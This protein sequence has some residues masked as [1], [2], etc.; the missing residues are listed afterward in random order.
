ML[1]ILA[2]VAFGAAGWYLWGWSGAMQSIIALWTG[3]IVGGMSV[4]GSLE[5]Q[6]YVVAMLPDMTGRRRWRVGVRD[7]YD[8]RTGAAIVAWVAPGSG[9]SGTV[10]IIPPGGS[11]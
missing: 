8:P 10:D 2:H 9:P 7:G 6:G 3:I 4:R 5:R 11:V 1:A